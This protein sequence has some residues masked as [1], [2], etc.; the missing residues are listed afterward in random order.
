MSSICRTID[1]NECRA[2]IVSAL[3]RFSG[4]SAIALLNW[5]KSPLRSSRGFERYG[6]IS[7]VTMPTVVQ[8]LLL[9][10]HQLTLCTVIRLDLYAIKSLVGAILKC[11]VPR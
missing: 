11:N 5:L 3:F 6:L 1:Q 4:L 9:G 7:T 10:R 2:G 8:W